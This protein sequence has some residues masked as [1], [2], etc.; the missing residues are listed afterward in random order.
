MEIWEECICDSL[1]DMNVFSKT[2][3]NQFMQDFLA[4]IKTAAESE[5]K[6]PTKTRGSPDG[7]ASIEITD[8][9]LRYVKLDGNIFL[10]QDGTEMSSSEAY[11][12]LIGKKITLEDGDVITFIKRLPKRNVYKELFFKLP[13]YQDGIDVKAISEVINKNMIDVV[14][15]SKATIRNEAQRHQHIGVKD[16]D[17]REVFLLDDT[18]TYRMELYIANLTD[19]TKI[20]YV[21]RYIEKAS[22]EIDKKIRKKETAEQIRLNQSSNPIIPQKTDLSSSSAKNISEGKTSREFSSPEEAK[23]SGKISDAKFSI[24]FAD[25]IANKQRKFVADGLSRISSE[26]L[27]K[28]KSYIIKRATA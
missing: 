6:S 11:N 16:F 22:P 25:E 2:D 9:G 3:A 26:E 20:A 13:G 12:A 15:G 8:D 23:E 1:G 17:L 7:K 21:K 5:T 14:G 27:M 28:A 19:G 10:R 18:A 4:D 24:E